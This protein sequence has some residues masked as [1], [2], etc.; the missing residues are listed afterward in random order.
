MENPLALHYICT[1][2][3]THYNTQSDEYSRLKARWR[4]VLEANPNKIENNASFVLTIQLIDYSNP[5]LFC[6]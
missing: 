4:L 6:L 5:S 3:N 2:L 1:Q